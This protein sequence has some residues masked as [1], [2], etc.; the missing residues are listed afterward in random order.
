MRPVLPVLGVLCIVGAA[1]ALYLHAWKYGLHRNSASRWEV[2]THAGHGL[3]MSALI[4]LCLVD[5]HGRWAWLIVGIITFQLVTQITDIVIEPTS[6]QALGGVPPEE[7]RLHGIINV[8]WGCVIA[9]SLVHFERVRSLPDALAWS[10][11]GL[12]GPLAAAPWLAMAGSLA[13][14]CFDAFHGLRMVLRPSSGARSLAD[15]TRK[16]T[17]SIR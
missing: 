4:L 8:L 15:P 1:D 13:I 12:P 3:S 10:S 9:L 7:Y 6:R 2:L 14:A 16:R 17:V 11:P 5:A